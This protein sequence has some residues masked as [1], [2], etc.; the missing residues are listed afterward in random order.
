MALAVR[1]VPQEQMALREQPARRDLQVQQALPLL[2]QQQ[3]QMP[4]EQKM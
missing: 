1:Q 2:R 3:W 4:P